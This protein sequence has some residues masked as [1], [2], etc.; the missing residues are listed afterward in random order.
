VRLDRAGLDHQSVV[1]V[2]LAVVHRS[3]DGHQRAQCPDRVVGAPATVVPCRAE[4][5]ELL[6]HRADADAEHQV[7]AADPV[8]RAVAL[9]DRVGMVVAQHQHVGGQPDPAGP[10]GEKRQRCQWIPVGR[11]PLGGDAF[12]HHDVFGAGQVVESEFV[13]GRSH[14]GDVLDARIAFPFRRRSGYLDHHGSRHTDS[15]AWV[16][17]LGGRAWLVRPDDRDRYVQSTGSRQGEV[18]RW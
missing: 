13:G 15:H 17:P 12:G 3:G 2:V 7:A 14:T 1:A 18:C 9:R 11:P 6:G 8:Q 5:L 4:E 10:R 16:I